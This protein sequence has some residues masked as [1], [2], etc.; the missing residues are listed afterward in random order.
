MKTVL[1]NKF[2]SESE[3][4]NSLERIMFFPSE[5]DSIDPDIIL[6]GKKSVMSALQNI[7]LAEYWV[8]PQIMSV[9]LLVPGLRNNDAASTSGYLS[10]IY[11]SSP[12]K[13]IVPAVLTPYISLYLELSWSICHSSTIRLTAGMA[14][15]SAIL[16]PTI[17]IAVNDL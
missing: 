11:L 16:I 15:D 14:K 8:F 5:M 6:T 1:P 12:A 3:A 7:V 4:A 17:C 2:S 10:M 13:L 9:F